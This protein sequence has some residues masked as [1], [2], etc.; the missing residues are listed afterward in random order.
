MLKKTEKRG[1]KALARLVAL[2]LGSGPMEP[3]SITGL[4]PRRILVIR[5]HNQMGDMLLA[6]PAFRGL[7]NRFPKARITLLAASIN[8]DVMMNNPYVDEVLTYAKEHNRR[9]PFRLIRFL[10][11]IRKRRFDLVIVL[12]T[13]SFSVT[14]MLL[15]AASGARVRAGSSSRKFGHDLSSRFYHLELPLPDD[16]ELS[17]MHESEHNLYPLRAMGVEADGLESLLVPTDEEEREAD[18]IVAASFAEDQPFVVV[19]PGAGKRQNIWPPERFAELAL[20]LR[21]ERGVGLAAVKGPVDGEVFNEFL[22]RC[23]GVTLLLSSPGVGLLGAVMK[24]SRLTLCNDTGIMHIA[25]AVGANCCALFGPTDPS[26][27]KPVNENVVAV[28]STDGDIASVSVDDVL[29]AALG[30]LDR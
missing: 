18:R 13:V 30:L 3:G 27:W 21:W 29:A 9:N 10:R 8:T 17:R 26:R 5:Q 12:N 1:K 24:R 22:K 4:E 19:H 25:G 6:V 23:G 2:F 7:R 11:D 28:R 15:A 20:R 16:D 14:S